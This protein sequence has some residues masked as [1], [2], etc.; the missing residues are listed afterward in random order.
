MM[1]LSDSLVLQGIDPAMVGSRSLPSVQE[2]SR[3][4]RAIS[5]EWN[6]RLADSLLTKAV[7]RDPGFPEASLWLAE[8]RSARGRPSASWRAVA[9]RA[10]AQVR[11]PRRD[12]VLANALLA[13]RT[14]TIAGPAVSSMRCVW[15][16]KRSS[17]RSTDSGNVGR[18][19][20]SLS[21]TA[22]AHPV[23]ASAVVISCRGMVRPGVQGGSLPAPRPQRRR[24]STG[25]T[26]AL[27]CRPPGDW[28]VGFDARYDAVSRSAG[29]ARRL[30]RAGPI[31][32]RG[33]RGGARAF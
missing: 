12:S 9:E 18:R 21:Q 14:R 7:E 15:R 17:L 29:M 6:L 20:P 32:E 10:Q 27:G 23:G 2:H 16:T 22:P 3:A 25:A 5:G 24:V 1:D 8:V 28:R 26:A 33:R 11:K 4:M 19:I 30:R 13:W 31:P